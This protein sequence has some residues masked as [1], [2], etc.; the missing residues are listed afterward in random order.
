M[1]AIRNATDHDLLG[2]Y[3]GGG[4]A[5]SAAFEELVARHGAMVHRTCLRILGNASAAEDAAQAVF[6]V[7][8]RRAGSVR[9]SLPGFL[10]GV[11]LNTSRCQ[12]RA[13][14]ARKAR[15]K[16]VA[17]QPAGRPVA[18]PST[19]AEW[20]SLRP[21][22]DG[23]IGRLSA[24]QRN[25]VVLHYLQGRSQRETA[26]ELGISEK[27]ASIRITRALGRLRELLNRRGVSL[28]A[29]TLAGAFAAQA[30]GGGACPAFLLSAVKNLSTA[31]LGSGSAAVS[32]NVASL[33]KGAMQMMFWAKVKVAAAVVGG[34]LVLGGGALTANRMAAGEPAAAPTQAG[35]LRKEKD[36][37][38][39]EWTLTDW[40]EGERPYK[41]AL[42]E[43][44]AEYK[45]KWGED[46]A[47]PAKSSSIFSPGTWKWEDFV[48]LPKGRRA[49]PSQFYGHP[50]WG[51]SQAMVFAPGD[52]VT[53][54]YAVTSFG[55]YHIDPDTKEL[56]H[57]G[58]EGKDLKY[59]HLDNAVIVWDEPEP[60]PMKD[61]L[62]REGRLRPSRNQWGNWLTVDPI[63]GRVF[64]SQGETISERDG[65]GYVRGMRGSRLRYVEKLLPYKVGGKEMLLPAI[66]DHNE[67]YK[68]VGAEPVMA[69]GKRAKPRLA[70]RTTPLKDFSM[71]GFGHGWGKKIA[72][73]PDGKAVLAAAAGRAGGAIGRGKVEI[74]EIDTGK[75]L[76]EV[77][78]DG[79]L[80][81][82]HAADGHEAASGPEIDGLLYCCRHP[83]CGRGPG[84][85]FSLD[86]KTG[87]ITRLYD[88]LMAWP[89][90]EQG[91]KQEQRAEYMK[92]SVFQDGP[93]DAATLNFVTTCFQNQCPRTGAIVSGGWDGNG[94]RRYHDG[95]VTTFAHCTSRAVPTSRPEWDVLVA[96]FG[97]LQ[98]NPDI[99]PDGSIYLTDSIEPDVWKRVDAKT[100][101]AH[102]KYDMSPENGD[103]LVIRLSRTDWPKEQPPNGYAHRFMSPDKRDELRL[104]YVKKYIADYE[105]RSKIY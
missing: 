103:I 71:G 46:W 1:N 89:S 56:A 17:M 14:T 38:G 49:V 63:T 93:A 62:D 43:R 34:V 28:G 66:L 18:G 90:L 55:V 45:K 79:E 64:F 6:L 84:R 26:M 76:G 27:A 33:A 36:A 48:I 72:I 98:S 21:E 12:R 13:E 94:L 81:K 69:G 4:T 15:E 7:L 41:K 85:L 8:A 73:T 96:N 44:E 65:R 52:E 104:E 53:A 11:A 40:K 91:G 54:V 77:R 99:A 105:E 59:H 16:E 2:T 57:V 51:K 5:A 80:P 29:T 67:M 75:V 23:A 20:E 82:P 78:V 87:K 68:K 60:E 70:V 101:E 22:L 25:A 97:R 74:I 83:G 86:P 42:T 10:H 95:F 61:G 30:G 35:G 19:A 32:G 100:R 37:F 47:G 39:R 58:V 24:Q 9:G 88:S 50:A 92:A 3:A 31:G 102:V